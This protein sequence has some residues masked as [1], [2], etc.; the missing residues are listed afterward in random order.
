MSLNVIIVIVALSYMT[1]N[2]N[3][4]WILGVK[5]FTHALDGKMLKINPCKYPLF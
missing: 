4:N 2:A 3:Q 5:I 1:V